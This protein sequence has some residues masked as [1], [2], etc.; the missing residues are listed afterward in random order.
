MGKVLLRIVFGFLILFGFYTIHFILNKFLDGTISGNYFVGYRLVS[1]AIFSTIG[2]Y[3]TARIAKV[4][5]WRN[6]I[7]VA[8]LTLVYM[9]ANVSTI[10][11]GEE[12]FFVASLFVMLGGILLGGHLFIKKLNT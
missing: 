3:F 12:S 6:V 11:D 10:K 8:L 5:H 7:A 2:G 1:N 4:N 9:L